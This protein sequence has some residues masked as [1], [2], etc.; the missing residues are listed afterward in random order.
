MNVSVI[1]PTSDRP[2][3]LDKC[4]LSLYKQTSLPQEI[5]VVEDGEGKGSYAVVKKWEKIFCQKNVEMR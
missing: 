2:D 3:S 1:I 5:I 4:L